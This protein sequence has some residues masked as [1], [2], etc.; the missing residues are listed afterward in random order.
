MEMKGKH[1]LQELIQKVGAVR[2][3]ILVL[4]GIMLLVL[5]LPQEEKSEKHIS[6]AGEETAEEGGDTAA[7][8]AM[9]QYARKQEEATEKILSKVDGIGKVKVM[10]T[11]A[12]SEEKVTLQDN[13]VSEDESE[14]SDRSGGSRKDTKHQSGSESVLV[15]EDG[16]EK[17][18]VVQIQS[19][20]VEG[21]VVVAQ[22]AA[23][24]RK[25]MEIIE[26]VQALFPVQSHKI[27]VMKME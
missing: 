6:A 22:G 18:Y 5:S 23:S 14:Q 13:T 2:L 4:A 1:S 10:L 11:L 9:Y 27:K 15:K 20:V 3:V 21:V 17:P 8:Q 24:G 19:P 26:A 7:L 16:K 25:E 12:S